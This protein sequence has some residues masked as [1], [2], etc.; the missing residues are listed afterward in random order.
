MN[1]G[2]VDL[3]LLLDD[4]VE[5]LGPRGVLPEVFLSSLPDIECYGRKH[6][7]SAPSKIFAVE[8]SYREI[9]SISV[10]NPRSFKD[11]DPLGDFP[12]FGYYPV[13]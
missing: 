4:G 3:L 2:R 6:S 5:Y 9:I 12:I 7:L 8:V 11:L 13:I 10:P 1:R